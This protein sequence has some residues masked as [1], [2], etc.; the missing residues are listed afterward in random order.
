MMDLSMNNPNATQE[1][2]LHYKN[3]VWTWTNL[4]LQG[5]KLPMPVINV[6]FSSPTQ[7]WAIAQQVFNGPE[8]TSV[9]LS[10]N[11]SNWSVVRQQS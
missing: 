7:G 5:V 6:A 4:Q 8:Q 3:G 1:Q 10:Y 11:G 2:A 9:L